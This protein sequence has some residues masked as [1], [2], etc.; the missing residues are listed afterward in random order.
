MHRA[1]SSPA[2]G[3]GPTREIRCAPRPNG[4]SSAA[5][6][7]RP[8]TPAAGSPSTRTLDPPTVVSGVTMRPTTAPSI[9]RASPSTAPRHAGGSG[10]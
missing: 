2:P 10:E 8:T 7:T 9:H 3:R 6:T 4:M 5:A 1:A